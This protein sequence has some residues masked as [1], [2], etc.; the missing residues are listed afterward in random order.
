MIKGLLAASELA[1]EKVMSLLKFHINDYCELETTHGNSLVAKD[2]SMAT[3]LMYGGFRS[4]VGRAEFTSFSSELSASLQTF[5]GGRGHQIQVVYLRDEDPSAEVDHM[6]RP[7]YETAK[8]L[9]LSLTDLLDEKRDV[10][11][12]YCMDEKVFLVLW[13]RP[14]VLDPVELTLSRQ[15]TREIAVRYKIPPM[16]NAQNLL[17][18][19]RFMVDRHDSYVSKV[20][21]EIQRLKGSVRVV[22]IHEAF[23]EMKRFLYKNTPYDWRATL[24][25]DPITVRWKNNSRRDVSELMYPRLDDQ[26]FIAPAVNGSKNGDGGLTDTKAVRL[27]SRIFAPVVIKI[28]PQRPQSFMALFSALNNQGSKNSAGMERRIPWSISFHIEGDGLK[29]KSLVKIFAGLLAWTSQ[30]NRNMVGAMRALERYKNEDGGAIV[31][32]QVLGLTWAEYGEEKELLVRRSKL[33]RALAGWGHATV[34]EETGDATGALISC[35]PG[36]TLKSPAPE[37]AAPLS[38][39]LRML[40]L[41]RPASPFNRASSIFR[42][43][44]GKLMPYEV[45]SDQQ[46]TWLTLIFGGPGSGKSVLSNRLNEEMCLLGGLTRLP[47][48]CV[49]D[50]GISSAGFIS[51]IQ[52][53][54]PENKKHLALYTRLQNTRAYG[55]N[56]FDTQLGQRKPLPREREAMK[57]FLVR[58]STPPE[59]GRAHT[60]MNEFVG[61]VL[62]E[63]FLICSDQHEKGRPKEFSLNVNPF[64]A[65]KIKSAGIDFMDATKW[66]EIT[67]S[68]FERGMNY[69]ASVA[70]RYAV[71]T[72]FD[73]LTVASDPDIV[74]E[75]AEADD[76]GMNVAAEFK[77]MIS[78]ARGDYP[79]F[80][81]ETQF[82][83]GEARVMAL[84]LQDVVTTGS[85]A[86]RKQASL[87]YMAALNAFM[88]KVSII[89]EDLDLIDAKYRA[90]HARRVDELAEDYKR[91]FCDEYHKTGSDENLRESFLIYGRESRK[92]L[93]EIVLSSQLPQDFRELAEIATTTLILDAGNETTRGTI[94]S[95]FGLSDTE[96]VALKSFVHGAKPG[97]GATFLAKIKTKDAE[98]SQLF[99]ATS[100]G[101]ELWGLSTTA[102]DRALRT[103][104]YRA[105]PS[106]EARQVLKNRFPGGSC[107]SWVLQKKGES[108]GDSSDGF[109]DEDVLTSAIQKLAE[110]MILEWRT[111]SADH[112]AMH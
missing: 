63:V 90:H 64:L 109:V 104:L 95:V 26:L 50:I 25:G 68:F 52:D 2:G 7:S 110:E 4:L 59:R 65:E 76:G 49:I 98:L 106:Q 93:L 89:K 77:L 28:P 15:E 103:A 44:D 55:I 46:N 70:Q 14:A 1:L 33:S 79:I 43:L 57:N 58:L 6:L 86:A 112:P 41:S 23:C 105:M 107:K 42:T 87:M 13:T 10:A 19:I 80:N 69:E 67:D 34:E 18:P 61:R 101:L 75:F 35:A 37:A 85:A 111:H 16:A 88:R 20:V 45:F 3:V 92:W 30:D 51:L 29:G 83:I 56:Q 60:Y 108:K 32:L 47:Y 31:K 39:V 48:I 71:P 84:D 21:D 66:W 22:E 78:A 97:V 5:L 24:P 99:T 102:E 11:C 81:A 36:I 9:E 96:V 8:N 40:P 74:R 54:L 12:R 62:D 27:G 38:D 53:G 82:D 100:G 17:R 73:V 91:L 72:L 94:R